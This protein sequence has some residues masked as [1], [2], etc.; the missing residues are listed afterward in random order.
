VSRYVI[1][2]SIV[3][4]FLIADTH[5]EEVRALF[6]ELTSND[7]LIVP[8]FCILE[9]TNVLWK[10]VRFYGMDEETAHALVTDLADLPLTS[11]TIT[12]LLDRALKIGLA[13][14]L[15][16]Y[17]SVYIALAENLSSSLITDDERQASAGSTAGIVL[18]SIMDFAS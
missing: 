2:A 5:T 8:E 11:Y 13:H 6:R 18:K 12:H 17:D 4:Q 9:C 15:A 14:Q 3:I 7:E 16:V 10:Q 1:D